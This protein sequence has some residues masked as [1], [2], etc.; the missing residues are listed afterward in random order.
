MGQAADPCMPRRKEQRAAK[1]GGRVSPNPKGCPSV[2]P[3]P[4][5]PPLVMTIP[6]SQ[7]RAPE[8][9]WPPLDQPLII[10]WR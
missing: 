8:A 3:V 10:T 7:K 9:H 5:R 2:Q 4:S 1:P 6:P